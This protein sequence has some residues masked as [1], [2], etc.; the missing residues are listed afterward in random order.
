MAGGSQM[1]FSCTYTELT[2]LALQCS[3]VTAPTTAGDTIKFCSSPCAEQLLPFSAQCSSTMQAALNT[4][5]LE[6]MFETMISTCN[7]AMDDHT[8][9]PIDIIDATCTNLVNP[10]GDAGTLW[11]VQQSSFFFAALLHSFLCS[12]WFESRSSSSLQCDV[13]PP[14]GFESL[15][16]LLNEHRPARAEQLLRDELGALGAALQ[17]A[18]AGRARRRRPSR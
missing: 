6:Q 12:T 15:R 3:S 14:D 5:G 4:F 2:G 1:Q 11:C 10:G 16:R 8:L 9:C 18:G 17:L 13:V 7:P